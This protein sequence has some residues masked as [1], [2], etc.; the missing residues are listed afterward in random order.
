MTIFI[1][2]S[3]DEYETIEDMADT[4]ERLAQK[5]GITADAIRKAI[6]RNSKKYRKVIINDFRTVDRLLQHEGKNP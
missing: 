5:Q 3:D 6:K 4:V 1:K 2:V